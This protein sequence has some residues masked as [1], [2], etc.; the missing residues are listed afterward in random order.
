MHAVKMSSPFAKM[1]LTR[2]PT[3]TARLSGKVPEATAV[4]KPDLIRGL[5][6]ASVTT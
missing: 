6:A 4:A 2:A 5:Q 3:G 1:T